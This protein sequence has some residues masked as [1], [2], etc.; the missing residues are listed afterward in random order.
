MNFT[1]SNLEQ[2]LNNLEQTKSKGNPSLAT[3]LFHRH[4]AVC[5]WYNDVVDAIH[6]D[7]TLAGRL[8]EQAKAKRQYNDVTLAERLIEQAEAKR[9]Y[10]QEFK[11]KHLA[12]TEE[13]MKELNKMLSEGEV[14]MTDKG[15]GRRFG[16]SG[17]KAS[18]SK[19]VDGTEHERLA[20]LTE[21]SGRPQ[22]LTFV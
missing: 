2:T 19:G 7:V 8:I 18:R 10:I 9:Q 5:G 21:N 1:I 11:T 3:Q 13:R 17:T 22:N 15:E 20:R 6:N 4:L 12:E 14:I 16:I